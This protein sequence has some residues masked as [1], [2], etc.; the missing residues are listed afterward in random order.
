MSELQILIAMAAINFSWLIINTV[1]CMFIFWRV[2]ERA[3]R[4]DLKDAGII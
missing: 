3:K 1:F 2:E 4:E